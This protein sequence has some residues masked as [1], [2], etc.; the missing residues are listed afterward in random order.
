MNFFAI[1]DGAGIY[2]SIFHYAMVIA[3]V[4]TA[5]LIFLYLWKI[6]RLDMGEEA[7]YQMMDEKYEE[8]PRSSDERRAD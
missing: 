3:F 4:G 7:K 8:T 5:L 6:N 1:I 2:G